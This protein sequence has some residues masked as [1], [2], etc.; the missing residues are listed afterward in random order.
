MDTLLIKNMVCP[1]CIMAV[2]D[3]LQAESIAYNKVL[4]GKVILEES[5]SNQKKIQFENGL[6][7]LGFEILKDKDVKRIELIKSSLREVISDGELSSDFNLSGY[8]K[9]KLFEDY[10]MLSHLFSSMEGVTIEKFF[11][12]LKIDKVKEFLFYEELTLSEIS[13]QLGYSSVQHLSTQFKKITGMTP[14]AYKRLVKENL[15][16]W[17]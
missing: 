2:E 4:M 9:S 12:A 3:L 11:I 15:S 1:R 13:Y 16:G 6:N 5:L 7:Q 10:S 14:T 17:K 8:I